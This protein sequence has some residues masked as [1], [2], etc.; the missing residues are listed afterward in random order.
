[1]H[2]CSQMQQASMHKALTRL[3]W[4]WTST[5]SRTGLR[6]RYAY[7]RRVHG[8][9]AGC[10]SHHFGPM[11]HT[12]NL[13]KHNIQGMDQHVLIEI[14]PMVQLFVVFGVGNCG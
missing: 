4:P 11:K 14:C 2:P 7:A 1:M 3:T 13:S 8:V 12:F 5:G 10:P 6:R 9:A